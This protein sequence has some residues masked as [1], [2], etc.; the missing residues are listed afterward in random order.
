MMP[1]HDESV[2]G[3]VR[4][5][6]PADD[7]SEKKSQEGLSKKRRKWPIVAGVAAVV[8]AAA[9]TGFFF[10]HE[11]PSFCN[12]ICHSPMDRYVESYYS[13]DASLLVTAHAAQGNE[14]LDC[15]V[16]TLEEQVGEGMKWVAGDFKDPLPMMEYEESFCLNEACHDLTRDDLVATTDGLAFNPHVNRHGDIACS[17][18]HSMHGQSDLY[19]GQCHEDAESVARELGWTVGG[20]FQQLKREQYCPSSK[21]IYYKM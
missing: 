4:N 18:C 8:L 19:C 14:C 3:K 9:G 1:E 7:S 11:Q 15:H 13:G 12:A 5:E 17:T 10:R 2:D 6:T 21:Y 16:P 20:R